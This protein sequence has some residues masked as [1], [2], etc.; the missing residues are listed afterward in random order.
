MIL[1][2]DCF[3]KIEEFKTLEIKLAA[4]KKANTFPLEITATEMLVT[5]LK[6]QLNLSGCNQDLIMNR[7]LFLESQIEI[8]TADHEY[9]TKQSILNGSLKS[10]AD[11]IGKQLSDYKKEAS[12]LNCVSKIEE[13]RQKT[14]ASIISNYS[15]VDKTRIESET[16]QEVKI[17]TIFAGVMI[18]VALG[19]I[20]K[21]S[22]K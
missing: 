14:V 6:S 1:P 18:V 15:E 19:M 13:S 10:K 11:A 21:F 7:C 3:K 22:K 12:L 17:R 4:L 5:N 2:K 16:T 20:I 8:F 9:Y